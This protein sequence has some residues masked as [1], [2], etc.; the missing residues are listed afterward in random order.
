[1]DITILHKAG[2]NDKEI[3]VFLKLLEYG[4][5][6]VRSLAEL[7]DLNR[8]TTYD[9]LKKL[10]EIGLVSYYHTKTK[11]RFVAEDP[12]K[13]LK[14]INDREEE[15]QSVKEKIKDLI[16]ELKSL[17]GK[18]ENKPVTKFYEG[19]EGIKFI[20]D[21]ILDTVV[22][23]RDKTY[24]IYSAEGVREDIYNAYP[25]Y[26]KKRI[27]QN[28][29]AQTIS[30]SEGGDTYGLDERKWMQVANAEKNSMTYIVIYAGKCAF[31]S[32]DNQGTSVGVIIENRMIYATQKEIFLKLWSFLK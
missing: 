6:S 22:K 18:E 25:S 5:I 31:L 19:R 21:D 23:E 10:Q 26:N 24:F 2:L 20:L 27:K 3:K 7:C 1:M 32:R 15:L 17:Q 14:V 28:I 11:Q 9:V 4:A 13:L 16:P 8:G 12:E 29:K 30:L